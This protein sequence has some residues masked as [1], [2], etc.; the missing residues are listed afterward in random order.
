MKRFRVIMENQ[1][2]DFNWYFNIMHDKEECMRKEDEGRQ[3]KN[4]RILRAIESVKGKAFL[5]ETKLLI[6]EEHCTCL[7]LVKKYKGK[8][9]FAYGCD[10]IQTYWVDQWMNGGYTGDNF[11]G[12]IYIQLKENLYLKAGYVC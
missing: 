7:S 9:D 11:A 3:R 6:Y 1:D 5:D 12:D 2:P 10:L 8:I 4:N